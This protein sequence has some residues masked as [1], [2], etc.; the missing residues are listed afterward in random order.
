MPC[1]D[2]TEP[3]G[4]Q[5]TIYVDVLFLVNALM[6]YITL[7]AAARLSGLRGRHRRFLLA[8]SVGGAYAILATVY[9]LLAGCAGWLTAGLAL[10]AIAFYGRPAF[11]RIYALYLLVSAAFAGLARALGA[12]ANRPLMVNGVYYFALPMRLLLLCAALGYALSGILL[13]G[14]AA[15]GVLRR[16]VESMAITFR[17]RTIRARILRDSGND[18][19]DPVSGRPALVLAL[20]SARE[21]L[22][23]AQVV[24]D[25]L[26]TADAAACLA[27]MPESLIG[28]FGLLPYRAVGT[29]SGLLL[30]FRPDQVTDT[31]GKRVDCIVAVS[32]ELNGKGGYEGLIGMERV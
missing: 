23:E 19:V 2:K 27:A 1:Y 11:V 28:R 10:C 7:L 26:T 24:L 22:G 3:E 5:M 25:P 9:P 4:K 12:A 17:S 30:Y 18:L 8:A 13:R 6:D 20:A 15:H 32:A 16:E 31:R 21:L 29:A 14:D